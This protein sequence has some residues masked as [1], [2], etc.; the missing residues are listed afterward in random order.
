MRQSKRLAHEGESIM[1]A[2]KIDHDELI[3]NGEKPDTVARKMSR[4]AMALSGIVVGVL[5]VKLALDFWVYCG[6]INITI[7][8]LGYQP[9]SFKDCL[10]VL[11]FVLR[12]PFIGQ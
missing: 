6:Q 11:P 9:I 4:R 10:E 12:S 7:T 2:N 5:I 1:E 8:G 3:E